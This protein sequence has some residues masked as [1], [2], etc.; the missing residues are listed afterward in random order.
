MKVVY[1][2]NNSVAE[3][4]VSEWFD[5]IKSDSTVYISSSIQFTKL[6]LEHLRKTISVEYFDLQGSVVTIAK[7]G[8]SINMPEHFFDQHFLLAKEI[9]KLLKKSFENYL[10][11]NILPKLLKLAEDIETTYVDPKIKDSEFK[12]FS[13]CRLSILEI[14][15]KTHISEVKRNLSFVKNEML[16]FQKYYSNI[17]IDP[18]IEKS[19]EIFDSILTNLTDQG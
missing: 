19:V 17:N 18:I 15:K 9:S 4:S 1:T 10:E 2:D 16:E 8:D 3:H 7:N 14:D 11:I 5:T 6:K 13:T 12:L